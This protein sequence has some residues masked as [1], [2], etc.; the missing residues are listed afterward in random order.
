MLL[1]SSA[2]AIVAA[3]LTAVRLHALDK[4]DLNKPIQDTN[5][6]KKYVQ[7]TDSANQRLYTV[8]DDNKLNRFYYFWSQ[9]Q[10]L[11]TTKQ[12]KYHWRYQL[13]IHDR[14]TVSRW[15]YDPRGFAQEIS[16]QKSSLIYQFTSA[17]SFNSFLND[18][19]TKALHFE[20]KTGLIT[21]L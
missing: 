15:V 11:Y 12:Q 8:S 6:A 20:Y 3:E 10:P 16:M 13:L 5:I 19:S 9:K 14:N 2:T 18:L 21:G 17:R 7:I 1:L 4:P